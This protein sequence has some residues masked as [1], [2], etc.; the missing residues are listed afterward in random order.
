MGNTVGYAPRSGNLYNL[1]AS[2]SKHYP[3]KQQALPAIHNNNIS[4]STWH[5]RFGH[6]GDSILERATN[7]PNIRGINLGGL[8]KQPP[9]PCKVCMGANQHHQ[10]SKQPQE[11]ATAVADLVRIDVVG[12]IAPVSF[13]GSTW[14]IAFTDDYTRWRYVCNLK[15]KGQA[16]AAIEHFINMVSTQMDRTVKRIRIDNGKEFGRKAL[17]DWLRDNGINYEATVPYGPEQNGI[18]ERSNGLLIAKVSARILDS[19]AS[20]TLWPEVVKTACYIL[21]RLPPSSIKN[22]KVPLQIQYKSLNEDGTAGP[23]DLSRIRSFGC[24]TYTHIPKEKRRQVQSS[25]TEQQGYTGRVRG[26]KSIPDL[27]TQ[28]KE[29]MK[30]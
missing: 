29:K 21:N 11:R 14:Y 3:I 20:Y 13:D 18:T 2:T 30:D 22:N 24:T 6:L 8:K 9:H 15:T 25:N 16:K 5:R 23:I 10:P 28:K 7:H 27:V 12:P 4:R 26:E 19:G 1:Q 17:I